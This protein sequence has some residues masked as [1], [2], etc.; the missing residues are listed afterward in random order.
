MIEKLIHLAKKPLPYE[1]S[2]HKF[3]DDAHISKSM[4]DAHLDQT[5]DGASRNLQFIE[6]SVHFIQTLAPSQ[7][8]TE[9]LDLGCG[10]GLY[11]ERFAKHGYRVTGVDISKSSIEYAKQEAHKNNQAIH[12]LHMNY[13]NINFKDQFDVITL[14]YCDYAVLAK[15]DRLKLLKKIKNA[16]KDGGLFIF[17]V[18]T[19]NQYDRVTENT[20]WYASAGSGFW[21]DGPHLC[22]EQHFIYENKIR[23]NQYIVTDQH[24]SINIYRIWDQYFDVDSL[25]SE[26][27]EVNLK[28]SKVYSDVSGKPYDHKSKTMAVIVTK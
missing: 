6:Q 5:H 26:L 22:L 2:T 10:P 23:L 24:D 19:K 14:I 27:E 25:A 15:A 8:K 18:F 28:I 1:P 9:L 17:D 16:L 21:K 11:A 20:S 4:L 13:L 3:W 12:Y 7:E